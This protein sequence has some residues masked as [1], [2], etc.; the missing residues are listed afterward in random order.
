MANVLISKVVVV[1]NGREAPVELN[2]VFINDKQTLGQYVFTT[3]AHISTLYDTI[4]KLESRLK[5]LEDSS[6][7]LWGERE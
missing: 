2:Q 1:V 5:S 3:N 4:Q 7:T 6:A